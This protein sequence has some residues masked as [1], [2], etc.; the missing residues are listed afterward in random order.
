MT[1]TTGRGSGA[2]KL[3]TSIF[4]DAKLLR[5]FLDHYSAAGVGEFCIVAQPHFAAWIE[6]LGSGCVITV[7]AADLSHSCYRGEI[8]SNE[9][10]ALR[11]RYQRGDEWV[12]IVDLDE[13]VAFPRGLNGI[14]ASAEA[15]GANVVRGSCTTASALTEEPSILRRERP[16]SA[17]TR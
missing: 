14:I 6:A 9:M 4:D 13:F 3:F 17:A 10:R 16:S 8:A 7:S 11:Q 15:D 5:R 12:V 1:S 2:I